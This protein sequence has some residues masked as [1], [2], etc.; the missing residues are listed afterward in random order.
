MSKP[1]MF[2]LLLVGMLRLSDNLIILPPL[3]HPIAPQD[4]SRDLTSTQFE[5]D[6][7]QTNHQHTH[8]CFHIHN[9]HSTTYK[10]QPNC[11]R[12]HR[13]QHNT[14]MA[15]PTSD[16]VP[17]SMLPTPDIEIFRHAQNLSSSRTYARKRIPLRP[18]KPSQL[19]FYPTSLHNGV[20]RRTRKN[21]TSILVPKDEHV[22]AHDDRVELDLT[23]EEIEAHREY[24]WAKSLDRSPIPA[25]FSAGFLGRAGSEKPVG[26]AMQLKMELLRSSVGGSPGRS[27]RSST[28]S[29][30]G[31]AAVD[32]GHADIGEEM[33]TI[34]GR[35][36]ATSTPGKS[37]PVPSSPSTPTP[38]PKST[39]SSALTTPAPQPT[40][41]ASLQPT[42]PSTS[43][44]TPTPKSTSKS[45]RKSSNPSK[46]RKRA[47]TSPPASPPPVSASAPAR[48]SGRR[49]SEH[50][51]EG[52]GASLSQPLP[53]RQSSF[54]WVLRKETERE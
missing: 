42:S 37:R 14:T 26:S 12:R 28:S 1:T 19:S 38:K 39:P 23:P 11:H 4:Q 31:Q 36:E 18:L 13:Y 8:N 20:Q 40:P 46:K 25:K 33:T 21:K 44:P 22:N 5:V 48:V 2:M 30:R 52:M 35:P 9:N 54:F 16:S 15:A 49:V 53:A 17:A 10:R 29:R 27:P 47:S 24:A 3:D 6:R 41:T 45:D 43:K 51:D 32:Q 34:S 50:A 7:H